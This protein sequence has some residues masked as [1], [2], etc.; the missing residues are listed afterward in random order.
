M[1]SYFKVDMEKLKRR[2]SERDYTIKKF[3]ELLD[4][5]KA[6]ER[7]KKVEFFKEYGIVLYHGMQG[8]DMDYDFFVG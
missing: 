3:H 1:S 8:N 4:P 2:E 5:Y 6:K 7:A